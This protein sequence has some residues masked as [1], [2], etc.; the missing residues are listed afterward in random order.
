MSGLGMKN[1]KDRD[2]HRDPLL[3]AQLTKGQRV[4][5]WCVRESGRVEPYTRVGLGF[6]VEGFGSESL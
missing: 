2:Y 4:S 1:G 5:Y 6:R 3:H